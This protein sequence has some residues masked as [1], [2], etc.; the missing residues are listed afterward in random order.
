MR[1][2]AAVAAAVAAGVLCGSSG[3]AI[4][5][6]VELSGTRGAAQQQHNSLPDTD[7]HMSGSGFASRPTGTA[8]RR[9]SEQ[10]YEAVTVTIKGGALRCIRGRVPATRSQLSCDWAAFRGR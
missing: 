7:K 6:E 8:G 2:S 5:A 4:A 10:Q 9:G 3:T 1:R